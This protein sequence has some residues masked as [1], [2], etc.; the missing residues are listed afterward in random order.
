MGLKHAN[1]IHEA[2]R[3]A[4]AD[5]PE[6]DRWFDR[7]PEDRDGKEPFFI[8]NLERVQGDE[9][10]A[11]IL[12]VGYGKNVDGRVLY[13]F[14]PLNSE[15]GERRLNV[16][17]T[18]ARN[19]MTVVSSFSSAD[20]DPTKLRAEGA[21]MLG[22]YLAYAESAGSNLG[23]AAKDKPY[24]NPFERDVRDH[25]SAAGIPLVAQFGCSGYWIDYAAQHPTKPGRMVLAIECDGASYHS[26]ATARD[27]DRLRQEHLERLGWSFHRIWSTDW[28]RNR[29]AEVERAITAWK[30]AVDA[31][32]TTDSRRSTAASSSSPPV[33]VPQTPAGSVASAVVA[34]APA[35]KPRGP[36][37]RIVAG[38][39][40]DQYSHQ[41][42]DA[43]IRWIESDTLLRT[44]EELIAEAAR[45]LGYRRRGAR[46]V[47]A[48][49]RAVRS[50]R[51]Q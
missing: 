7:G 8:K 1:R 17:I 47:D 51:T 16:A 21:Q 3:R 27:R 30:A 4:R 46:I 29:E 2:L 36:R 24:L 28:F 15:G 42:L 10:D 19:R 34:R 32:D 49:T 12:T 20:M 39:T 26:S 45:E 37:P 14:G 50:A 25:L 43:L 33:V 31:A 18:R 40:I 23:D 38:L 44:E 13:R 35:G 9:R 5:H 41:D 11:I 22:R 6:F 48:L